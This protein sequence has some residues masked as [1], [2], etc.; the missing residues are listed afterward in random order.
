M[1]ATLAERVDFCTPGRRSRLDQA[2]GSFFRIGSL[3][4]RRDRAA[5]E[6][7]QGSYN[8]A[9]L[10]SLRRAGHRAGNAFIAFRRHWCRSTLYGP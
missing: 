4:L 1:K 8:L 10:I 9:L 2:N 6:T 5:V 7:A 3:F